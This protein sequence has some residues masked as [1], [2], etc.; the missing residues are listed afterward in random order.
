MARRLPVEETATDQLQDVGSAR[1]PQPVRH[2]GAGYDWREVAAKPNALPQFV[3]E[4]DGLDIRFV[5]VRSPHS[6]ALPL[7]MPRGWPGS[8]PELLK[9]IGQLTDPTRHG[10]QPEDAFDVVIPSMPGYGSSGHPTATRWGSDR[11]AR[12]CHEL[13]RRLGYEHYVCRDTDLG[14]IVTDVAAR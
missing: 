10:G 14:W 3:T 7:I 2:F 11:T 8:V 9:F 12:A 6:R 13:M 1:I 4:I 5:H